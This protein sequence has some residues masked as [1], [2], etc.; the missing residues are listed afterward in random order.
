MGH[1]PLQLLTLRLSGSGRHVLGAATR[2]KGTA[3][4]Q[5]HGS[6]I[7]LQC[8]AAHVLLAARAKPQQFYCVRLELQTEGCNP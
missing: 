4:Q 3:W 7:R 2:Q 5:P 1:L 8:P 6:N